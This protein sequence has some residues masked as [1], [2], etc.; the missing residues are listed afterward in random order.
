MATVPKLTAI[1]ARLYAPMHK[2]FDR[3]LTA[4][5]LRRDAFLDRMIAGEI[6]HLRE[7]LAGKK[8]SPVA[9]RFIA[10]KLKG[11]GKKGDPA[12]KQVSI[13]V[14][15][16]TANALRVATTKHNLVRD[17]FLNR[18]ITLLRS[19][20]KLLDALDLPKKVVGSDW[21]DGSEPMP[22]SPLKAIEATE[23]DPLYYLR[24]ACHQ[25]HGCGL[26]ALDFPESVIGFSCFLDDDRIPGTPEN[27]RRIE[28]ETLEPL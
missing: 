6:Q 14:R 22:T 19:S 2:D 7:D 25:R 24:N 27:A 3:Q 15:P 8:L 9:N 10:G 20:D 5:L 4:A 28:S 21:R 23:S 12:L 1:T 17:A 16:A 18:L 11:M 13:A 26:Y